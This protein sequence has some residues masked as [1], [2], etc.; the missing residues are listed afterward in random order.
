MK[1]ANYKITDEA[2]VL[3]YIAETAAEVFVAGIALQHFNVPVESLKK[4]AL[5]AY[6]IYLKDDYVSLGHLADFVC[7][8]YKDLENKPLRE[9]L[10]EYYNHMDL[11]E[12][13]E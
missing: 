11:M 1:F 2:G 7:E 8:H 10:N 13:K 9:Q 4:V 12:D 5:M 6:N 3:V